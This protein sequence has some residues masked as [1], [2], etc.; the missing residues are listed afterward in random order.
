M[1]LLPWV[2]G[3]LPLMM[4]PGLLFH[5]DSTPRLLLL[6]MATAVALMTVSRTGN[7]LSHLWTRR[8]G[9]MLAGLALFQMLWLALTAETSARP[10]FSLY[11]SSWRRM[12]VATLVPLLLFTLFAAGWLCTRKDATRSLLRALSLSAM[13]GAAYGIAQYFDADPFQQSSAY[14]AGEG[15]FTIVRP[16]GTL[17]HADYFA[18]WLVVVMFCALA[19]ARTDGGIWRRMAQ[20]A[21]ALCAVAI[22]LTGTRAALLAVAAGLAVFVAM[23]RPRVRRFHAAVA[24]V[25]IAMIAVVYVSPAGGR[26]RA[27]VHWSL[28]DRWGGARLLLWR[29]SLMMAATRP[30]LGFGPETFAAEFPHFE[31]EDLARLYPDWYHESPHNT[32][33]DALTAEGLPGLLL[34]IAWPALGILAGLSLWRAGR[35]VAGES[36]VIAPLMAALAGA[37]TS[38]MFSAPTLAPVFATLLVIAMLVSLS[39]ADRAVPAPRRFLLAP[40]IPLAA[41]MVAFAVALTVY[42]AALA[43]FAADHS[44]ASVLRRELPGSAEDI[45][46]SRLLF[47]S[48]NAKEPAA[49]Y[50]LWMSALR[51]AARATET[52]DDPQNAW[53][54]LA[55]FAA[56]EN[57]PTGVETALRHS[58][59]VAPNWFKP[60]WILARL[61]ARTGRAAQARVEAAK[62]EALDGGAIPEVR[63]TLRGISVEQSSIY[64]PFTRQP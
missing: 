64:K 21:V 29:D 10:W 19:T 4:T 58:I 59:A 35:L 44:Y 9:R 8:T 54:N 2:A 34:I 53:F 25:V 5:Y 7:A 27:R 17:G 22:L 13:I 24:L 60:H 47:E 45:Y 40:A 12:G 46:C 56:A 1:A 41:G 31:S 28:D 57:D 48:R 18:W 15:P 14:R 55:L 33:L 20:A 43:R 30:V 3:L 42:D 61:L 37:C 36:R 23:E 39:P 63:D 11:G 16:P 52:A 49:R 26:L 38:A 32:A 50:G 62:A 51:A 6:A